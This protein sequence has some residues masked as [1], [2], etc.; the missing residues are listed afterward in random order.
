MKHAIRFGLTFCCVVAS[1]SA[2]VTYEKLLDASSGSS[3]WLTY[4]GN[5]RGWRYSS[6]ERINRQNA[7]KL[8]LE[9]VYQ[10]PTTLMVE[11][12]PLVIDGVMYISE[13]PS[14]VVALDAETGRQFWRYRRQLPRRSTFAAGR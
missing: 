9:W 12:T 8:T 3:D 7:S 5:Y 13:P 11:T 6:L 4:S 1:L 10:M 14:N 2:Q